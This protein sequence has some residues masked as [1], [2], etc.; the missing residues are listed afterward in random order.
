MLQERGATMDLMAGNKDRVFKWNIDIPEGNH[1]LTLTLRGETDLL[2]EIENHFNKKT[3]KKEWNETEIAELSK[4]QFILL[5]PT[6]LF[7]L[8]K[9]ASEQ[10]NIRLITR[11]NEI[12]CIT[13]IRIPG[14]VSERT[15]T[16]IL[17][18][19]PITDGDRIE[20]MATDL[21][22]FHTQ[23]Q[24]QN[25]TINDNIERIKKVDNQYNALSEIQK[26]LAAEIQRANTRQNNVIGVTV[27][28]DKK[29]R[30]FNKDQPVVSLKFTKK[31][32]ES[33]LYIQMILCV[34]G[35]GNANLP[36][37]W[38]CIDKDGREITSIAQTECYSNNAGHT[39]I[40]M[41]S[42][43]ISGQDKGPVEVNMKFVLHTVSYVPF[44]IINPNVNDHAHFVNTQSMSTVRVEEIENCLLLS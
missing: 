41:G 14:M 23:L 31:A 2:I 4:E 7:D 38:T 34:Y 25:K 13:Q 24:D 28:T 21:R 33:I 40:V 6:E 1:L 29:R 18:I 30:A 35:E 19:V 44:H 42:T 5:K 8:I 22:N 11:G 32:K 16:L 3:Y 43:V 20:K 17:D 26:Q 37:L 12:H 36:Q 27:W 39:R 15:V 10:N 9:S